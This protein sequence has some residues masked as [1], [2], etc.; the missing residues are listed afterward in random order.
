[1]PTG[2]G[3]NFAIQRLGETQ[4]DRAMSGKG[5]RKSGLITI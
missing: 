5:F 1:M 4:S 3:R 2:G